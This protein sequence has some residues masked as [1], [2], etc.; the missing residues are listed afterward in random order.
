MIWLF[1]EKLTTA[2]AIK[3]LLLERF[4][5]TLRQAHQAAS[6]GARCAVNRP[7]HQGH[8]VRMA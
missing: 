3:V 1:R 7:V 2:G 4:D 6:E 5:E 8:R